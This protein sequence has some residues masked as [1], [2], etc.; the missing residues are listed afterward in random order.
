MVAIG[1]AIGDG[2]T[3]GTDGLPGATDFFFVAAIGD[4]IGAAGDI[5]TA[6]LGPRFTLACFGGS[7]LAMGV[8]YTG[9][10]A[11]AFGGNGCGGV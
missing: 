6:A 2:A 7:F 4:A 3:P 11:P 8:S 10:R 1:D 5:G 9:T